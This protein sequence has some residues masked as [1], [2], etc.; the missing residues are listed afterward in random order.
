MV[1]RARGWPRGP[2]PR[3]R[4]RPRQ[5]LQNIR[6]WPALPTA[7]DA[8]VCQVL[9]RLHLSGWEHLRDGGARDRADPGQGAHGDTAGG[10]G[11][12]DLHHSPL[13]V[14][15][16]H[17]HWGPPTGRLRRGVQ[18]DEAPVGRRQEKGLAN[19]WVLGGVTLPV[20]VSCI[21]AEQGEYILENLSPMTTY[22]LRFGCKNRVGF[23]LWG[24]PQQVTMSVR[25]KP[26]A[27]GLN[28]GNYEWMLGDT[29]ILSWDTSQPYHLSWQLP[30]DNGVPI[31]HFRLQ[32]FPVSWVIISLANSLLFT[33]QVRHNFS[34]SGTWKRTGD[35]KEEIISKITT[36][37]PIM[38]PFTNT[39]IQIVL[40]AH[41][42]LGYSHESI[43]IIRGVTGL[44][45]LSQ[46]PSLIRKTKFLLAPSWIEIL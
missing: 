35:I 23:S 31:D 32:Y 21:S 40:Q 24:S 7:G 11:Q 27:P 13:Q 36:R 26:E 5:E 43:L 41:N 6:P 2:Q 42:E 15:P 22:D 3:I 17:Q 18:G 14:R 34:N 20:I 39:F 8:A 4:L 46:I 12:G 25:G 38:F 19:M 10:A 44:T 28:Y 45:L 29:G 9:R 30:E 1:Q 16:S 37:Y 33:I